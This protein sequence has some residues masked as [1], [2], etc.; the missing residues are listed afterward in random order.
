ML[1]D[2]SEMKAS[3]ALRETPLQ[4]RR[5]SNDMQDRRRRYLRHVSVSLLQPGKETGTQSILVKSNKY[6]VCVC[7]RAYFYPSLTSQVELCKCVSGGRAHCS[8]QVDGVV[9]EAVAVGKVQ[10]C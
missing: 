2:S 3:Q 7:V 5:S 1:T 6:N 4:P 10:F 9:C 8:Q